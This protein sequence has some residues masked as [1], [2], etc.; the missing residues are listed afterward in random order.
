MNRQ[1][2]TILT[3]A[4]NRREKLYN[5]YSSLKQQTNKHFQWLVIDDG[6][7]DGTREFFQGMLDE[8]HIFEIDYYYKENG[9]KHSA[10]NYAH[11]Y[12]KGKYTVI[13]DSDDVMTSNAVELILD[14]WNK[15]NTEEI[16]EII[17]QRGKLT[18]KKQQLDDSFLQYHDLMATYPWLV[19][20]GM[21]SDHC[22]TVQTKYLKKYPFP[23]YED[24]NFMG[25]AWLWHNIGQEGKVVFV[26]E[27]IYL[28]EY[29]DGGLTK[30]GRRLRLSN[31]YGQ[32][33][34]A[35]VFMDRSYKMTIR[36]KNALLYVCYGRIGG[37]SIKELVSGTPY[38]L[39]IFMMLIPAEIL[40]KYW[41][42]KYGN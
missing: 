14:Y 13:V 17:F 19:N 26:N 28:C 35:R 39:L 1:L 12:I 38:K 15:Y 40:R 18:E 16:S 36:I 25:E 7:N 11:S 42:I 34:H 32:K 2:L 24:E 29:L 10:I 37:D 23:I 8:K 9:G 31:P 41:K 5:L 6:S 4:Y 30:S 20:H 21:H 27:I 3:P 33:E 22:E